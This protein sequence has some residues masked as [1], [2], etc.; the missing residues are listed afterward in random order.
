MISRVRLALRVAVR[1]IPRVGR[2]RP[3]ARHGGDP[4]AVVAAR[5]TVVRGDVVRIL[6]PERLEAEEGGNGERDERGEDGLLGY[7]ADGEVGEG[8]QRADLHFRCDQEGQDRFEYL[9]PT[10]AWKS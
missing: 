8:C 4:S 10:S 7:Q 6:G 1:I 9:L 5:P 2:G 3:S